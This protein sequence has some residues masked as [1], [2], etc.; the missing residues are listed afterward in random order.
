MFGGGGAV[1]T[2]PSG[3][4]IYACYAKSNGDVR[5][6]DNGA[7]RC[8]ANETAVSWNVEGPQ[9]AEGPR[10]LQ[11]AQGAQGIQG[12]QGP[13]G[14]QGSEGPQGPQGSPG[15]SEASFDTATPG[16]V[17]PP[18]D[19]YTTSDDY[20]VDVLVLPLAPGNHVVTVSL[21]FTLTTPTT[22]LATCDFRVNGVIA[23]SEYW[24][25][26][27]NTEAVTAQH[28]FSLPSPGA[29]TY[30]CRGFFAKVRAGQM[31]AM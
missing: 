7:R 8:K 3:N 23:T 2:V 10:G 5:I 4:K 13:Q 29:V 15:V 18:D 12:P 28:A 24:I 11:G 26:A 31:V 21:D 27:D 19:P 20:G 1:A 6:L 25:W 17:L 16:L 30:S 9:G 22:A 14:P